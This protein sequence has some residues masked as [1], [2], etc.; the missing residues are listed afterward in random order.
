MRKREWVGKRKESCVTDNMISIYIQCGGV[1]MYINVYVQKCKKNAMLLRH[2]D[3]RALKQAI[4]LKA[5][6]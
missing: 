2:V 3:K 4:I 6:L 5:K 1:Y